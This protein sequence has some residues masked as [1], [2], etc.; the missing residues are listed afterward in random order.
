MITVERSLE[1]PILI[2]NRDNQWE[3][4]ATFNGCPI[5]QDGEISLVYRAIS[6]SHYYPGLPSSISSIGLATSKDGVHF[7][8]RYQLLRP[9]YA[10]ERFGCEDPRVT[11]LDDQYFIFYTALSTYP[12]SPPGIK[13]GLALTA[14]LKTIEQKHPVT[15][16]NAKAMALF[17]ERIGGKIA[18]VLTVHTD[19]PPAKIGIAFFDKKEQIWSKEYWEC[20]YADLD[21][22]IIPLQRNA[23]DHLEVGAPPLRTKYGWLLVYS[24][25]KNYFAPPPV[26]GIEAVLLNLHNP[27]QVIGQTEKPLMVPEEEYEIYGRVPKVIFPSGAFIEKGKLFIYYGATDTTC[28]LAS[29]RLEEL[30]EELLPPQRV[31]VRQK[32]QQVKLKRFPKNPIIQPQKEHPWEAKATF[33]PAAL[34]LD[35]RVHLV[36]RAMSEDN[37]SVL[38]YASSSD[39]FTIKERLPEPIYVPREDFERKLRPGN[40]GCED[41]RLTQIGERIYMCYTAFDGQNPFRVALTSIA[42]KDFL[43]KNW[44]WEKP[45]LISPPGIGDKNAC[46]FP[47]KIRGKYVIL[48]R[49]GYCVCIDFVDN[50]DFSQKRWLAS[51]TLFTP[52]QG[53]WD[54]K[55]IGAAAPPIKTD[56]G[57]LLLY[58][59]ISEQDRQYRVGAVLLELDDPVH[60]IG[61]TDYPLLEPKMDYERIGQVANVVFPCGAV[62]IDN[63]LLVYYG[64]ADQV[65]GV[66]SVLLDEL[67]KV[68]LKVRE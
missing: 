47:E 27:R 48:H 14:D 26:F 43:S 4:E 64:A 9:E 57:W 6:S 28:C 19:Q 24:Y 38:G 60:L 2:P 18:A 54:S 68:L 34:Y 66:A 65:V 37:T 44:R 32:G 51:R 55:K 7:K 31:K 16:F 13:V 30:L 23:S 53:K 35:G 61:R 11:K 58:H 67:L 39:G 10:W 1:N 12:F 62:V 17:P 25:I 29:C 8:K 5:R 59:G 21:S 20:W 42:I 52:R 41:P 49:V 56:K 45:I 50:L 40:S 46:I 33:N 22:H 36:Y 63:R 3:S 15:F